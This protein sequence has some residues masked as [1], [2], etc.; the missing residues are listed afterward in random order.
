MATSTT[1]GAPIS[2]THS[3]AVGSST[4]SA[5]YLHRGEDIL[6]FGRGFV[7]DD[8]VAGVQ[9]LDLDELDDFGSAA[10]STRR[11]VLDDLHRSEDALDFGRVFVREEVDRH[12]PDLLRHDGHADLVGRGNLRDALGGRVLLGGQVLLGNCLG[13]STSGAL[14]S[15]HGK[16]SFHH[17]A[18]TCSMAA[19]GRGSSVATI[20]IGSVAA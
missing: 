15:R 14:S 5:P 8:R 9:R 11:F 19:V 1:S 2:A 20:D 18:G 6:Y 3:A 16:A 12:R 17:S 7:L 10:T 13:G 4:A